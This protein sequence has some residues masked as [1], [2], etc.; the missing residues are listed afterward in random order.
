M[1]TISQAAKTL[2]RQRKKVTL[3]C[4]WCGKVFTGVKRPEDKP[5]YHCN[6]CKCAAYRFNKRTTVK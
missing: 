4:D 1:T 2:Q 3:V 5:A 6:A